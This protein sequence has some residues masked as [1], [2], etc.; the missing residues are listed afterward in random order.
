[1]LNS[2]K[3]QNIDWN[4]G[5]RV[6]N[7]FI[8]SGIDM[9]KKL[10]FSSSWITKWEP[11][12]WSYFLSTETTETCVLY[13]ISLVGI[14]PMITLFVMVVVWL[15]NVYLWNFFRGLILQVLHIAGVSWTLRRTHYHF[16]DWS[17]AVINGWHW[18]K[19]G[20]KNEIIHYIKYNIKEF[21]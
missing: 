11:H 10:R 7:L 16:Y 3:A 8:M 20:S 21:G 5:S 2:R 4:Y 13:L 1:M 15:Q 12:P 14:I 18:T 17:T 9:K 6:M 19:K